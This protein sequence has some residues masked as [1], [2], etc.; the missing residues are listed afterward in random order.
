MTVPRIVC[1]TQVRMTS[2]RLPGKVLLPAA[3]APLLHHHLTRLQRCRRVDA[4]AVATTVNR[5]DDP[6]VA[7]AEG[8]GLPVFRGDEADVLGRFAGCAAACGAELVI[9]VTSDCPLIDP[10]LI[11]GLVGLFLEAEPAAGFAMIDTGVLPR[12]LDAE[13]FPRSL[14]DEAAATATAAHDREHVTPYIRR[15]TAPRQLLFRGDAETSAAHLRWCVDESADY[16]LIRRLLE[17]LGPVTPHFGWRDCLALID[18]HPDWAELNRH[19]RQKEA[20]PPPAP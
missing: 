10:V 12:G 14:L 1:I 3:G 4:V 11:D 7:L 19:V 8:L 5:E 9:R 13:M 15:R 2:S 6:V 17:A 16:E 18:R 20:P